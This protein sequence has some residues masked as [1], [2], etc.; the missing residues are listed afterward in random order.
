MANSLILLFS[1]SEESFQVLS[2]ALREAG[3]YTKRI[4]DEH[5][6]L[7]LAAL[8]RGDVPETP[9]QGEL[10]SEPMAVLCGING[11]A[12]DK[13]LAVMRQSGVRVPLKAVCTPVNQNWTPGYLQKQLQAERHVM[14]GRS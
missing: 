2:S 11:K 4:S 10:L 6:G 1:L 12:M 3:I 14:S 8:I 13:A 5:L 7:R 9:W